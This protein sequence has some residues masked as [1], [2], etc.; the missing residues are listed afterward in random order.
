MVVVVRGWWQS[1]MVGELVT[2]EQG[3][4]GRDESSG[5]EVSG[6]GGATVAAAAATAM[7]LKC[8]PA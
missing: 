6:G 8:T 3:A 1:G 2:G 5:A 4:R 7:S